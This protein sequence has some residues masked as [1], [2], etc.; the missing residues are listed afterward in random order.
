MVEPRLL[1]SGNL[2]LASGTVVLFE[3]SV[4]TIIPVPVG[5]TPITLEI[6][7][8][9]RPGLEATLNSG[10]SDPKITRLIAVNF[11]NPSGVA[12]VE[13]REIGWIGVERR[14]VFI[15]LTVNTVVAA[16]IVHYTV[17][18]EGPQDV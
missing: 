16:K 6:T 3:D 11:N 9:S 17:T 18:V 7:F 1:V 2:V 5:T 14:R 4:L 8:E 15:N 12:L 13:P 10:A